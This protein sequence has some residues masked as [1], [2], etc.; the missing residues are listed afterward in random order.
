[1]VDIHCHLIPNID[2][3]SNDLDSSLV[4]IRAM[5]AGGIRQ[6]FLTS[7]YMKGHYEYSRQ[8]YDAR[9]ETL[10]A[11]AAQEKLDISLHPGF[12]IFIQP[13]ILQDIQANNL[14]LGDSRYVLIESDLNGL[15]HDFYTNV[16]PLLRA[17]YK[18]ILAHAERY[19]SIMKSPKEARGLTEQN[20]Y[21][22]VNAGSLLGGYGEKVRQTAWTLINYGWAHFLGSDDHVRGPYSAYFQA[23][24]MIR[25]QLDNHAAELITMIYPRSVVENSK[26][27][28]SYVYVHKPQHHQSRHHRHKAK[29][30]LK[31]IF[32]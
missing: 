11:V 5:A 17:G 9:L 20:I 16:Y 3:G 2:D 22:Q 23:V 19:V 1:M 10:R 25:E 24:D 4:Q 12:E 8:D 29:S 31:K 27:P 30:F 32:G 14:C 18:P 13:N 28:Y 15:P 7:H 21:I 26:I 6:A